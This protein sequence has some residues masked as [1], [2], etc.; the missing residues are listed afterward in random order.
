MFP[1]YMRNIVQATVTTAGTLYLF[2]SVRWWLLI[3]VLAPFI[4]DTVVTR[5]FYYNVFAELDQF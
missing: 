3:S 1:R 2:G 4:L 5:K